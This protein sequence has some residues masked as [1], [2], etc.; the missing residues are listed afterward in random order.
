M[1]AFAIGLA[2]IGVGSASAAT[3]SAKIPLDVSGNDGAST[4][5]DV[6]AASGNVVNVLLW[7][8]LKGDKATAKVALLGSADVR[9]STWVV[10]GG[11]SSEGISVKGSAR[12]STNNGRTWATI[13]G[14]Q[15]PDG[16]ALAALDGPGNDPTLLMAWDQRRGPNDPQEILAQTIPLP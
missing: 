11:I 5:S 16:L 13:P 3:W 9:G 10:A 1:A 4:E 7:N 12:V 8:V 6:T 15:S 14:S 2:M